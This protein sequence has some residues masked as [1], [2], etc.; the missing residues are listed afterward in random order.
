VV[1]GSITDISERKRGELL[2][3][4]E[5]RVFE[6]LAANVDLGT[7]LSAI[8]EMVEK[9]NRDAICAISLLNERG[10]R[11]RLTAA[12]SLPKEFAD[13]M[14]NVSC[15][16]RN[17][18]CAAA[19]YLRRQVIVADISRDA[20]WESKRLV[21]GAAGLRACWSTL[22]MASDGCEF[23]LMARIAQ[24]AGIAIERR[25]GQDA[26]R[27]SE[28]RYRRLFDNVVEGVY[29][30][31]VEGRFISVNPALQQ[32]VGVDSAEELLTM[33]AERLYADPLQRFEIISVIA[34]D[35]E[36]RDAEFQLRR[37]D[38]ST[39]TV[40]ENACSSR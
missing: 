31:T 2:A 23:E 33:P 28:L 1:R 36:I 32:M 3:A 25:R 18:S 35:G 22:I 20:L 12:P 4:G 27:D 14:A 7:T 8:T 24:L 10:E 16:L 6:R 11:L 17:G 38:G 13:A 39:L 19:I 30:S 15:T 21:A 29:S 5:K 37:K 40:V 9:V 26:L 34:R